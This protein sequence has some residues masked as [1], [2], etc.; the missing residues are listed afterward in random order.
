[1]KTLRTPLILTVLTITLYACTLDQTL[2]VQTESE[3]AP[4]TDNIPQTSAVPPSED[5]LSVENLEYIGAFRLPGGDE[6]PRT[7]AYGGNAMTFNPDGN[8]SGTQDNLTGSLF[9]MGHERIAYGD[10]PDGNQIAEVNIPAPV[11]SRNIEDLNTAE[12]LQD[13]Q[14]VMVGYFTHLEEIPRIGL[15]YLN[16]PETGPKIHIA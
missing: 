13:F 6:R 8:P 11:I 15:T 16:R 12:F 3:P 1:M 7:F 4:A 5:A 9:V 2:L 10:L 14:N